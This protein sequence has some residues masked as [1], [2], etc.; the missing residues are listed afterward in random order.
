[1]SGELEPTHE[2]NQ[3]TPIR[4]DEQ[5]LSR[6]SNA[7]VERWEKGQESPPEGLIIP[8]YVKPNVRGT[9]S[10]GTLMIGPGHFGRG[11][12]GALHHQALLEGDRTSGICSINVRGDSAEIQTQNGLFIL[13]QREHGDTRYEVVGAIVEALSLKNDLERVLQRFEDES[14]RCVTL[15]VTLAGYNLDSSR[16]YKLDLSKVERDIRDPRHPTTTIGLLAEGIRRRY[17]KFCAASRDAAADQGDPLF[18]AK[19]TIIPCDNLPPHRHGPHWRGLGSYLRAALIDY[20]SSSEQEEL[21]KFIRQH[22]AIPNTQVD[23][24]CT[25]PSEENFSDVGQFGVNDALVTP[26]EPM[27]R[28]ALVV[29]EHGAC[30]DLPSFDSVHTPPWLRSASSDQ[31]L[32]SDLANEHANIKT[33]TLNAGHVML[34]WLGKYM[35]RDGELIHNLMSIPEMSAFLSDVMLN[36]VQPTLEFSHELGGKRGFKFEK[37][38]DSVLARFRNWSLP[39]SIDRLDTKGTEK[40]RERIVSVIEKLE[41]RVY[42]TPSEDVACKTREAIVPLALVVAVWSRCVTTGIDE[43]GKPVTTDSKKT[44]TAPDGRPEPKDPLAETWKITYPDLSDTAQL[45]KFKAETR[46]FGTSMENMPIFEE[47]FE[48][49]LRALDTTSLT[50]IL[51]ESG[52]KN[53]RVVLD[54]LAPIQ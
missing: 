1:M 47:I 52:G 42:D 33:H 53:L 21:A 46:I 34:A 23:R 6:L 8:D 17:Q 44:K 37:Y 11:L 40:M 9:I 19:L 2:R 27:P 50:Q 25:T 3:I 16:G 54:R 14:V 31:V 20:C 51:K 15:S 32:V 36:S 28:H 45:E 5:G 4:K 7:V 39:D 35:G 12:I 48:R 43:A 38:V 41:E 13:N 24:I 29:G 26:T 49:W 18:K 22:I 30:G 10:V